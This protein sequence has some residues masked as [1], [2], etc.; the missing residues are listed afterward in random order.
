MKLLLRRDQRQGML[1]GKII[2]T[3]DVRAQISPEE[4]AN[5]D[6]YKLGGQ[7]LYVKNTDVP[8]E[9]GLKG[10]GKL[11]LFHAMNITI[12]VNDLVNG[13]KIECKDIM[14]MLAAEEQIKES[15]INFGRIL[16]AAAH[17]GGE[18]VIALGTDEKP[19]AA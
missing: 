19:Q 7:F 2:F 17:F 16:E 11:L 14:E 15:A 4:H 5:I 1:G 13:K 6:R 3:L 8:R 12:S 18:E 10:V 9:E